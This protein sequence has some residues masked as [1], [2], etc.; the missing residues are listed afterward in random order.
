MFRRLGL[1]CGN[2]VELPHNEDLATALNETHIFESSLAEENQR[3]RWFD[4][5]DRY[6]Q[7]YLDPNKGDYN[8]RRFLRW[9]LPL[10]FTFIHQLFLAESWGNHQLATYACLIFNVLHSIFIS[11]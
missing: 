1:T 11:T 9:M 6:V 5:K 2:P 10:N 8:V 3:Q 7:K 4:A